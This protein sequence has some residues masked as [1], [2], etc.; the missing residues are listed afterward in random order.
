MRKLFIMLAATMMLAACGP[1]AI[2]GADGKP[3]SKEESEQV[4]RRTIGSRL[5]NRDYRI[6]VSTMSPQGWGTMQL[7]DEW[8]LEIHGDSIGSVLPYVGRGFNIPYGSGM[9]LHFIT[10]IDSYSDEKPEEGHRHITIRCHTT[11]DSYQYTVDVYDNGTA[12][13]SVFTRH[14]DQ[15][16]YSG[17]ID[18]HEL[19]SK[20]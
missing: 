10:A 16:N 15:V 9:G 2:I 8:A 18:L 11:E 3:L 20:R 1:A 19:Y 12:Y 13:I 6:L 17:K 4:V 5:D 14:R 7:R